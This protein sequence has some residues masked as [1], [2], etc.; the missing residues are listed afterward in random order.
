MLYLH[1]KT[2]Y[3][4]VKKFPFLFKTLKV[5]S[6]INL[7]LFIYSEFSLKEKTFDLH[8]KN[9]GLKPKIHN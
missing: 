8:S 7:N 3:T 6:L 1:Y 4:E 9:L 2:K 5:F